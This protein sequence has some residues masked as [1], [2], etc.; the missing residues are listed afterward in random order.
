MRCLAKRLVYLSLIGSVTD[1]VC[2][3]ENGETWNGLDLVADANYYRSLP[4]TWL[5]VSVV[6][7]IV[8]LIILL[9]LLV[10][11]KRL[12]LALTI[13]E[14]GSRAVS[15]NVV[16]LF[17]PISPCLKTLKRSI[18][19]PMFTLTPPLRYLVKY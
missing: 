17:W 16:S 5:I 10:I 7:S 3:A 12:R 18:H 4:I 11:F 1:G 15:K 19:F 14:E 9:I 8:L 13:V 6:C 2:L